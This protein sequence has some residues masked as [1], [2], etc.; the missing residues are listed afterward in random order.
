[1]DLLTNSG[2]SPVNSIESI[3][4]QIRTEMVEG[5]KEKREEKYLLLGIF[6]LTNKCRWR[7]FGFG[8]SKSLFCSGS[9]RCVC[10]SCR[11]AR[12]DSSSDAESSLGRVW[13]MRK[14]KK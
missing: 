9:K 5:E 11:T 8:K 3:L 2:W 4:I 7:P 13:K 6:C 12:M 1:M 10:A 14:K